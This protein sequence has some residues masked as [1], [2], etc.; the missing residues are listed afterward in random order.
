MSA[1]PDS[2]KRKTMR[3]QLLKQADGIDRILRPVSV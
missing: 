3:E 2:V 1:V